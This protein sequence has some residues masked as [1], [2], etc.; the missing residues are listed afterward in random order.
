MFVYLFILSVGLLSETIKKIPK[1][2]AVKL[3]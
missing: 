2:V 3:I 1:D